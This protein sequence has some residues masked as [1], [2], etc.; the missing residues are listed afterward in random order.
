MVVDLGRCVGCHTCTIACKMENGLPPSTLWRTVHDIESGTFPE[1]SRTFVPLTCMHCADPPCHDACPTTATKVRAD[2]IVW[3]DDD[4]CIGCGSCVVACPYQARHLVPTEKYYFGAPTEPELA[5]YNRERV[6]IC[7]KCHFC[8]H[9]FDEAPEGAVP[10]EDPEYTPVCS[11]SCIGEAIL[12]GD[13]NNP[14]SR[15]ARLVAEN[16]SPS[17]MLEHLETDPSVYYLNAPVL[18]P[19]APQ[20]QHTWHGL[21]VSNFFCGTTGAGLFLFAMLYGWLRGASAPILDLSGDTWSVSLD[22]ATLAALLAPLLVGVGLLSVGAEAGRPLRGFNVFRNL[23]R[24]WMSRESA[25]AI[26]FIGLGLLDTLLWR[27]PA[28]QVLAGLAGLGVMLAQ[29]IVLSQ[30]KGVP[31]WNVPIM[32]DWFITSGLATGAGMM[33][34]VGGI[35]GGL[36]GGGGPAPGWLLWGAL[37]AALL[38]LLVW[39]RYLASRHPAATFRESVAVLQGGRYQLGIVVLGHV[40]PAVLLA[41]ALAAGGIALPLLAGAA[42]VAGGLIAKYALILKAGFLVDLYDRFGETAAV[43]SGA[44]EHKSAPAAAAA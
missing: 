13:L 40:A 42:L 9:K 8:Y 32:T 39:Y 18:E 5:T 17:R 19:Q 38:D 14:A 21:A 6:G 34:V 4:I 20:L 44:T 29:G 37:A 35:P 24:S 22:A 7:T 41:A 23:G 2:G 15:V 43:S 26:V 36:L 3:I 31:A 11:S 10:G 27:N 33:L 28:V 30:A 12:F 25:F 1:V 16:Q